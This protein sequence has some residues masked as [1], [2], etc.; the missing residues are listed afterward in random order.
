MKTNL[1]LLFLIILAI[2]I[3]FI[4]FTIWIFTKSNWVITTG[5]SLEKSDWLSFWGSFLSYLGTIILGLIALWQNYKLS[6]VNKRLVELGTIAQFYSE[7]EPIYL[8]IEKSKLDSPLGLIM[9]NIAQWLVRS[10]SSD[11]KETI[12]LW[13]I[14]LFFQKIR[15]FTPNLYNLEYCEIY[16]DNINGE[17]QKSIIG[18]CAPQDKEKYFMLPNKTDGNVKDGVIMSVYFTCRENDDKTW[19]EFTKAKKLNMKMRFKYKNSFGIEAKS[20]IGLILSNT[21]NQDIYKKF[22]ATDYLVYE[23]EYSLNQEN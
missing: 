9:G 13:H 15:P 3:L 22:K 1:R 11:K 4:P 10:E 7:I 23:N 14:R 19:K 12:E 8:E 20:F 2:S 5:T 16:L 18:H 21:K 17:T 6:E